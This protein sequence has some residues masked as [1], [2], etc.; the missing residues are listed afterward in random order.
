MKK[1]SDLVSTGAP[2]GRDVD[3]VGIT[4]DSRAVRCGFL[5]AA[6]KGVN[7]DGARF[8]PA[9]LE[10]G[11]VAV[12]AEP[13]A[14]TGE[15]IH[16]ADE[17]PRKALAGIAARFYGAQPQHMVAVT[18]TNGKS[19][20]VE[21]LRQIWADAG[22]SAAAFGTL[23]VRVGDETTPLAHTTPDPVGVHAN[24]RA[25]AD[26]GVEWAA[27]EAS[28]HGLEQHR[29][30]AVALEAV[31]FSNLTQDHLDYHPTFED[32]FAA[33]L[34]LFDELA[35][36][37]APAVI[38]VDSDYGRRVAEVCRRR[39]MPVSEVG[40]NGE[41]IKIVEVTARPN[42]LG[43]DL[44][45]HGVRHKVELPLV[46]EF[47]TLNAVLA[48]GLALATGCEESQVIAAMGALTGVRGRLELVGSTQAGAPVLVDYAHTPDGLDKL[49]RALRPHTVGALHLVFGCGGDRDSAKR[50]IMGDI[51]H[52]LADSVIVT[53]DNPRSEDPK[54]IR[55]AILGACPG[56]REIADRADAI[57]TG[58]A[59][60]ASGDVLVIAGKGHETGQI[61]GDVVTP[62]DDAAVAA[63]A[64]KR[65]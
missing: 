46:G 64:L 62:F 23:G 43:L 24:L 1:L 63:D 58:V 39:G 44:R 7:V 32:Y 40:W 53:D 16:I 28:S 49:L 4:A 52:R 51:A 6:L 33:K 36:V 3:I 37:D 25:L 45:L 54:R 34:R 48:A 31:G 42:G 12:L 11:A 57:A 41:A 10:A 30:D 50:S 14:D 5:F 26:A 27:M 56:A 19:S 15:A 47:Q 38:N 59:G 13:G 18:G 29:V 60:L 21:F 17:N 65:A 20:T 22:R 2:S 8:I 55:E 9:A 61:V 35:P